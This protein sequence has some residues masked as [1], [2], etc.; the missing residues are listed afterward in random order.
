MLGRLQ[1]AIGA[2]RFNPRWFFGL[3]L[4]AGLPYLILTGPFRAADERNHFL[5]SYEIS[6]GR[7]F[8]ARVFAKNTGDDLP[9]SLSRLSDAL[10]DHSVQRIE[11]AQLTTARGLQ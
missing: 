7:F 1:A 9:A 3:Y 8:S 10:G 6:E 4:L 11:P 5:R 2:L